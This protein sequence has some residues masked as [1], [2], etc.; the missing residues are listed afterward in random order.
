[1]I[2]G[3]WCTRIVLVDDYWLALGLVSPL[4]SFV[5]RVWLLDPLPVVPMHVKTLSFPIKPHHEL[6]SHNSAPQ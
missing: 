1:M 2:I 4:P 5:G 6:E 3:W